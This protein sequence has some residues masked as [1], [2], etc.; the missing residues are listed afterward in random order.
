ML[1]A[2]MIARNNRTDHIQALT[3]ERDRIA[4]LVGFGP[5]GERHSDVPS[6]NPEY[7]GQLA[8]LNQQ[9]ANLRRAQ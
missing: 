3:A 7:I 6:A 2:N 9:I 5:L 4:V 8:R 1:D